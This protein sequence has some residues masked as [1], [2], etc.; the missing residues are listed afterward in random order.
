MNIS[1]L[2][3]LI[4]EHAV[5]S[6]AACIRLKI[7]EHSHRL[8]LVN[9][10]KPN[11]KPAVAVP[12][13]FPPF[14]SVPDHLQQQSEP[15]KTGIEIFSVPADTKM[16]LENGTFIDFL[17]TLTA[18]PKWVEAQI[19]KLHNTEFGSTCDV[20]YQTHHYEKDGQSVTRNIT[21]AKSDYRSY[22]IAPLHHEKKIPVAKKD[23]WRDFQIGDVIDAQDTVFKWYEST[24]KDVKHD[25]ILV[26]YNGWASVGSVFSFFLT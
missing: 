16:Q 10:P 8:R 6:C 11:P 4:C 26:H 1:F 20:E 17:A 22:F 2:R 19:S 12:M 23:N 9:F 18:G 7:I 21:L 25:Q 3:C 5:N 14:P 13:V 15:P 24:V